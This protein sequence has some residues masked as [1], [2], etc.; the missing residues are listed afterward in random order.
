MN[1]IHKDTCI[2]YKIP[3]K[4]GVFGRVSYCHY[5]PDYR[6]GTISLSGL[7][8]RLKSLEESNT[9]PSNHAHKLEQTQTALRDLQQLLKRHISEKKPPEEKSEYKG[10]KV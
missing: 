8:S 4:L 3:V 9:L 2:S 6:E 5:C 10:I 7:E 1:C